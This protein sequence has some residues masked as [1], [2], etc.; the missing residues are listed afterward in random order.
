MRRQV[1]AKIKITNEEMED[2]Q[3]IKLSVLMAQARVGC[4]FKVFNYIPLKLVDNLQGNDITLL[5]HADRNSPIECQLSTHALLLDSATSHPYDA[6]SYVWGSKANQ[7]STTLNGHP[8]AVTENLHAVLAHLR[9][10]FVNR[11]LWVD[12]ISIN[13][14]DLAERGHQVQSMAWIYSK[15]QCVVVW[16]G[17]ASEDSEQAIQIIRASARWQASKCSGSELFGVSASDRAAV[18]SLLERPWFERIWVSAQVQI[19]DP[20]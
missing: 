15:A 1:S 9:D 4:R 17:S 8:F 5:A 12:A 2:F 16:L 20:S 18:V 19:L 13:Q 10:S 6:L 14:D 11:T 7:K 3:K